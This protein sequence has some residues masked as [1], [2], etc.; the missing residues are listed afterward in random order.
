MVPSRAALS[1]LLLLARAARGAQIIVES[2]GA[3]NLGGGGD[4]LEYE[5]RLA[6]VEAENADLKAQMAVVLSALGISDPLLPRTPPP[7]PS[8]PLPPPPP[9]QLCKDGEVLHKGFFAGSGDGGGDGIQGNGLN[10][11]TLCG[12]SG[13]SINWASM[14]EQVGFCADASRR[15][16]GVWPSQFYVHESESFSYP[17]LDSKCKLNGNN[18]KAAGTFNGANNDLVLCKCATQTSYTLPA[19]SD[20]TFGFCVPPTPTVGQWTN[21]P[22]GGLKN[23]CA[24]TEVSDCWGPL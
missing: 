20:G 19:L 13:N 2:G 6:A 12:T 10:C 15:A 24:G 14:D 8:S 17:L 9:V 23:F 11:N 4:G 3:I 16:R 18:A 22:S 1:S 5:N 21:P 7:S